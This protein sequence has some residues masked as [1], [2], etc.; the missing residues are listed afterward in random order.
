M[1]DFSRFEGSRR[2]VSKSD[3]A[4]ELGLVKQSSV[5]KELGNDKAG[6]YSA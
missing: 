5:I 4:I 2:S 1:N 6:L 3:S